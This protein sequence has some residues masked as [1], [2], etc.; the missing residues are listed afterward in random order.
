VRGWGRAQAISAVVVGAAAGLFA[1][2]HIYSLREA[3]AR[4]YG[5]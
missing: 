2:L 3:S 5:R 4:R 1:A